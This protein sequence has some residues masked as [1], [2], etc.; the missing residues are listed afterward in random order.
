MIVNDC[1]DNI[2]EIELDLK[3]DGGKLLSC[4]VCELFVIHQCGGPVPASLFNRVLST[5]LTAHAILPCSS[6]T[7]RSTTWVLCKRPI[8]L[9]GSVLSMLSSGAGAVDCRTLGK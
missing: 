7:S 4:S 3:T 6:A 8:F 1:K 5:L 2:T 9:D